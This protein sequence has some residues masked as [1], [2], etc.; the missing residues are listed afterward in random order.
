VY[1]DRGLAERAVAGFA[2]RLGLSVGH[3]ALGIVEITN[4]N[5][6]KAIRVMTVERGLD[7]RDFTLLAFGGAGP[8]HACELAEAADIASVLVPLAP[9]VT[10]ALGTLFVDIVHDFARSHIAPLA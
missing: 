7:P 3:A 5:M 9:G 10:S 2:E 8:M 1:V 4:S 6:A